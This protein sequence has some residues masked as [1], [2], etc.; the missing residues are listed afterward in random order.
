MEETLFY[1]EEK[2]NLAV[3]F[4]QSFLRADPLCATV[5]CLEG[6]LG[7]GKTTLTKELLKKYGY[8]GIVQSPTFVIAKHYRTNSIFD[9]TIHI[10]AYRI[11]DEAE[12]IPL[13]FEKLLSEGNT[14]II[15]EW[16]SN[17]K[18]AIPENALWFKLTHHEDGR[19]IK[20]YEGEK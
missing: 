14:L 17:I 13:G 2:L 9:K 18:G 10:D 11:E 12:L 20:K 7:A 19:V 4:I 1:T 3:D 5:L 15:V 6:D 16:P 8:L